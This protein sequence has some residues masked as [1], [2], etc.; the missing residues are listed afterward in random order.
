MI[1]TWGKNR[2]SLQGK[3]SKME[4]IQSIGSKYRARTLDLAGLTNKDL[5]EI[6]DS[7]TKAKPNRVESR[8]KQDYI[9]E[10]SKTFPKV[11]AFEKASLNGLKDLLKAVC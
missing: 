4:L 1:E 2:R 11:E 8:R 5:K 10:L 6:L 3:Q 7:E 9:T